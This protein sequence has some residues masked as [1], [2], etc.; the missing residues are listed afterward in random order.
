[1]PTVFRVDGFQI[2]IYHPPREH[3]PA[4]VHVL[5]G[6]GEVSVNLAPVAV[7]KEYGMRAADI[8]RAVRIV[9][10]NVN[11]LRAKWRAMHG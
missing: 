11:T 10:A 3:A 8:V 6:A 2:R 4:H 5:K 7:R 1:M 9:E